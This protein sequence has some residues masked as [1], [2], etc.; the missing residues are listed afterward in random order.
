[1]ERIPTTRAGFEKLKAEVT[2]LEHDELPK[3]RERV[4]AARA[5]GDLSENAE[6]HGARETLGMM[7]AK[8]NALKDR[9]SR[10]Y[11]LD[12]TD[13]PKDTVGFGCTVV[14]KD[15][16]LDDEEEVTLVG[17]GEEDYDQGKILI[18]SPFAQGLV[19]KKVGDRA[20]ISVPQGVLKFQIVNIRYE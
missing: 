11:I 5:E 12:T 13:I 1:M 8:V 9:L 18:S 10:L 14:L 4:A 19:G 3:L 6:Y 20:E 2:R 17:A 7:E 16:D 15:L